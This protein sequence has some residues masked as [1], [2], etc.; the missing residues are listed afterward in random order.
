MTDQLLTDSKYNTRQ[1]SRLGVNTTAEL[2][3]GKTAT[4][5]TW[6]EQ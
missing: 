4:R 3:D 6:A 2:F 1:I 5:Q